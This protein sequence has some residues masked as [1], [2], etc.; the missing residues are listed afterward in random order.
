MLFI[1]HVF[2]E[3]EKEYK[4]VVKSKNFAVPKIYFARASVPNLKKRR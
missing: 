3:A 2:S 4:K 1:S